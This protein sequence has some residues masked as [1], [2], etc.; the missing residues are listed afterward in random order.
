VTAAGRP[1]LIASG[2]NVNCSYTGS[3]VKDSGESVTY[4]STPLNAAAWG[5]SLETVRLLLS[6]G[7]NVNLEDGDGSTPLHTA[8]EFLYLPGRHGWLR[9]RL[10]PSRGNLR[11]S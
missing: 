5:G 9:R 4:V 3:Y 6:H 10:A 11:P 8:D 2:V 1:A 7:A